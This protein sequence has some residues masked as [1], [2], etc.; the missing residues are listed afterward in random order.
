[1]LRGNCRWFC[2]C[3]LCRVPRDSSRQLCP[4][5]LRCVAD[6]GRW[7]L[8]LRALSRMPDVGIRRRHVLCSDTSTCILRYNHRRPSKRP[9]DHDAAL[10]QRRRAGGEPAAKVASC[11]RAALATSIERSC[12]QARDANQ[13]SGAGGDDEVPPSL[14]LVGQAVV[15]LHCPDRGHGELGL[16]VAELVLLTLCAVELHGR[17]T[18]VLPHE[19]HAGHPSYP[20]HARELVERWGILLRCDRSPREEGRT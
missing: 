7:W 19:Q 15:G 12:C 10:L 6:C 13:G 14:L 17:E 11:F 18:H 1:M 9:G 4:C 20:L 5:V 8:C 3:V 16:G 2:P